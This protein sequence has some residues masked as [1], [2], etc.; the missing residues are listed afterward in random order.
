MKNE[1]KFL[2]RRAVLEDAEQLAGVH[3]RSWEKAYC[4]LLP[5]SAIHAIGARRRQQWDEFLCRSD[6]IYYVSE[7]DDIITG[8]VGICPYRDEEHSP[9]GEIGGLYVAPE[10][11]SCGIGTALLH[12]GVQYLLQSMRTPV[13]LWVLES[14]SRARAFYE[15]N[16]FRQDGA[17]K[18][19]II[20]TPQIELR[21]CYGKKATTVQAENKIS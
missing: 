18:K 8:F 3:I 6:F 13:Y 7:R 16:L 12:C 15:K 14:N 1:Q 9:A 11:W 21:Y 17:I 10:Y 5:D 4:G 20:G 2:I 19:V